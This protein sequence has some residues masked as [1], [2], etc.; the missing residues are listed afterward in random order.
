M[1][2]VAAPDKFAGTATAAEVATAIVSAAAAAGH[3]GLPVPLADGGE[4]T[5][6]AFGGPNQAS[7]VTGPLGDPVTCE[8]RL[9]GG[10][11]V[12]ES[13]KACGLQLVGGPEGN[14]PVAASTFGVGEII[15]EALAR[16]A[17]R[18]VI[19][20]G[21][22]A[23]SDGGLGALSALG[24]PHRFRGVGV[25]VA[26][27]VSTGFNDA[28]RVFGPQKGATP[29]QVSW[30]TARLSQLVERYVQT[31]GVDV[32]SIRGAGAAGGL[33]GGLAALGAE[34]K[35]GFELV[36]DEVDLFDLLGQA[37]VVITGEGR[38]DATSF[39][40]KVVG[41]VC[42]YAA[43]TGL[44]VAVLAGDIDRRACPSSIGTPM[45]SLT[46]R[47][48]RRRAMTDTTGCISD[49]VRALIDQVERRRAHRTA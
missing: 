42:E 43:E 20:V 40:G 28:A 1:R 22:S 26:C 30:L 35:G 14:D 47:F 5:L 10:V 32:S 6:D 29:A 39:D 41:G 11:A 44:P 31:Y 19:G 13:A 8:W 48:G 49:A 3:D 4:G 25:E 27:D 17:R 37:D 34:L 16:G 18:L 15:D 23:S 24:G 21:G 33:A 2:I 12:I 9:A 36:A 38:L 45:L 7:V 46:E